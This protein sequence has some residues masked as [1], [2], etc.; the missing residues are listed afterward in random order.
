MNERELQAFVAVAEHGRMD[1][2]AKSLGY[3]QPAV[4]YQIKCLEMALGT[5]LF[6]RTSSGATLTRTGAL[7]L[8]SAQAVLT[9]MRGIKATTGDLALAA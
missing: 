9:L 1:L 7:V 4:S 5:K 2:A 8:P 6:V 3:S